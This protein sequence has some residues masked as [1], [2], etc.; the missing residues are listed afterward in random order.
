MTPISLGLKEKEQSRLVPG[1]EQPLFFSLGTHEGQKRQGI[2]L[3]PTAEDRVFIFLTPTTK[4][5]FTCVGHG[6][7]HG[8]CP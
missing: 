6:Q 2:A 5:S 4:D 8:V 3:L 1:D 7:D